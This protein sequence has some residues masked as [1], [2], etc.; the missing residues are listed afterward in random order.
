MSCQTNEVD[1][2]LHSSTACKV[3]MTCEGLPTAHDTQP[4][5]EAVSVQGCDQNNEANERG[6][7]GIER[8]RCAREGRVGDLWPR[9]VATAW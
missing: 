9:A 4:Q 1:Q 2:G 7:D 6:H 5:D 8:V 3:L